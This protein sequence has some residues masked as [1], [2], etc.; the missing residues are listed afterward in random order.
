M[1]AP[2]RRLF[3]QDRGTATIELALLA[4][5]LASMLI[6][7]IDM[8][9]A[10]NRKLELEQGVQRA[11]ERV[12]Q[13]TGNKTPEDT[14]KEEVATAAGVEEDQVVVTFS[15][16]CAGTPTPINQACAPGQAEV[17]YLN[18]VATDTFTP[19]IPLAALGMQKDHFT[20]TV[21][22]GVRTK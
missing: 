10:F 12:M 11:I 17:R 21:E 1:I 7:V 18:V 15:L 14:I 13:T 2:V 9:T 20:L 6:G 16:T 4:P 8:T 5:V 19:M 22:S 3:L